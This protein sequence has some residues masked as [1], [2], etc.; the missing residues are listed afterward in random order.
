MISTCPL[1]RRDYSR[2]LTGSCCV[3]RSVSLQNGSDAS[4]QGI[5]HAIDD[6]VTIY[7]ADTVAI[8][9][10]ARLCRSA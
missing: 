4:G 5:K 1:T 10:L 8:A 3:R 9:R 2:G 7:S 6:T